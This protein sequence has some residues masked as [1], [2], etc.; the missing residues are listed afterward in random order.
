MYRLVAGFLALLFLSACT[1]GQG[2]FHPF[3]WLTSNWSHAL[4]VIIVLLLIIIVLQAWNLLRQPAQQ[5]PE[6]F[7][8]WLAR[9]TRPTDPS[10]ADLQGYATAVHWNSDDPAIL[11]QS[12]ET[13]GALN[14]AQRVQ[15]AAALGKYFTEWQSRGSGGQQVAVEIIRAVRD[16]GTALFLSFFAIAVFVTLAV[17]ISNSSFFSSLAQVDQARGLITFLVAVA[18]VALVLLAAINIFWGS[19]DAVRITAAKDLV[20]IIMGV[21]GTILGFYFGSFNGERLLTLALDSPTNYAMPDAGTDIDVSATAKNGTAPYHYDILLVGAD[22]QAITRPA[23]NKP[24]EN[25]L[26]RETVKAPDAPGKYSIAVLIRDARGLQTKGTVDIIVKPKK[27]PA[28]SATG[29]TKNQPAASP[30]GTTKD[31]PSD[32]PQ[33]APAPGG[34]ASPPPDTKK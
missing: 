28:A 22:G 8:T 26:V 17:G 31:Q 16:N 24:S 30:T 2:G 34:S 9:Q 1:E 12:I 7:V 13:D 6:T 18:A 33:T 23:D 3:T 19:V 25:G 27:P 11:R 21:L 29:A 32:P 4:I 15:R 20:T 5:Q 10:L 14:N